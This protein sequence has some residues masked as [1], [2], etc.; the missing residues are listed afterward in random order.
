[1][2]LNVVRREL[3]TNLYYLCKGVSYNPYEKAF[4]HNAYVVDMPKGA[5]PIL[6]AIADAYVG[7]INSQYFG[8]AA[9]SAP[10]Q[11]AW[12]S[13]IN[14]QWHKGSDCVYGVCI[15]GTHVSV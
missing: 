2:T 6:Q 9:Y 15:A 13:G 5:P 8:A 11:S 1:M 3:D 12:N 4:I 7:A 14:C 10:T